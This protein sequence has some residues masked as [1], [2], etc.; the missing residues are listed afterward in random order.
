L[1]SAAADPSFL[2][3]VLDYVIADEPLLVAFAGERGW[4]PLDVV[5]ARESLAGGPPGET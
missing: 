2:S 5:R 3:A 1:R 4:S